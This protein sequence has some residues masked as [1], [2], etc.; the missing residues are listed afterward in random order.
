MRAVVVNEFGPP[1]TLSLGELPAPQPGPGEVLIDIR[2]TA[3]NY[4]DLLVI[5]GGYQFLPEATFCARQRS[6]RHRHRRGQRR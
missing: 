3:A 4:V 5:S 2:A 1:E 6:G